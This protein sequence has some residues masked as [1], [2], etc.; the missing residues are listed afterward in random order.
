M[1]NF[2]EFLCPGRLF[3]RKNLRYFNK[4]ASPN[5]RLIIVQ[6][7]IYNC[8]I[9]FE[10]YEILNVSNLKCIRMKSRKFALIGAKQKLQKIERIDRREI[11]YFILQRNFFFFFFR[12]KIE[13]IEFI[14]RGRMHE[15]WR[16]TFGQ[17]EF[18]G[19]SVLRR[20]HSFT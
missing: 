5:G 9:Q 3:G 4:N 2:G 13:K 1:L 19:W 20:N 6:N 12:L 8:A 17:H 18:S 15:G 11:F 16:S 7:S 10:K 14:C